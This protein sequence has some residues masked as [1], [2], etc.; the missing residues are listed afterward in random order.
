MMLFVRPPDLFRWECC[1]T[2]CWKE[3]NTYVRL[4]LAEALFGWLR[5]SEMW[6][7]EALGFDGW[8]ARPRPEHRS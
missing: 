1:C 7:G 3:C 5:T 8:I 6:R 2:T 4:V